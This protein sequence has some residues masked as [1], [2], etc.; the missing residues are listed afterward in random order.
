MGLS[1]IVCLCVCQTLELSHLI[2]LTA[3]SKLPRK[4]SK[5]CRGGVLSLLVQEETEGGGKVPALGEPRSEGGRG[6]RGDAAPPSGSPGLRGDRGSPSPPRSL[7]LV[8]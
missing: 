3:A 6:L 7:C 8:A 5:V 2:F 1:L 4:D